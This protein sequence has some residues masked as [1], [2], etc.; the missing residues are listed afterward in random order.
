MSIDN[1]EHYKTGGIETIDFI[2]AKLSPAAYQGYLL[3]NVMKYSSRIFTKG[4]PL[5]DVA[6]LRWYAAELEQALNEEARND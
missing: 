2:K 4:Q 3:G 5:E 1:P 6:K